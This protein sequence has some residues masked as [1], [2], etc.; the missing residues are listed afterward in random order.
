MKVRIFGPYS[1]TILQKVNLAFIRHYAKRKRAIKLTNCKIAI[2]T[3]YFRNNEIFKF[4]FDRRIHTYM[5]RRA[6]AH[7]LYH[8]N[9]QQV[10]SEQFE[11]FSNP[12]KRIVNRKYLPNQPNITRKTNARVKK[13]K[14]KRQFSKP[15]QMAVNSKSKL[16]TN[17]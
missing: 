14:K 16:S 10:I 4:T 12:V 1:S 7:L 6:F 15:Y 11:F 5:Y 2:R 9:S 8:H 17:T 3:G 13:E